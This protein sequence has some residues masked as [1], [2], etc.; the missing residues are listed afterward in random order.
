[1]NFKSIFCLTFCVLFLLQFLT[2][3]PLDFQRNRNIAV[4][5]Q[6]RTL[7]H[8][9]AGGLNTPQFSEID[10][11]SD[12]IQDLFVFDKTTNKVLTFINKGT[13]NQQD[14]IYTPEYVFQFPPLQDW[15][16]LRDYNADGVADIFTYSIEGAGVSVYR[17]KRTSPNSLEFE[18]TSTRLLFQG[19]NGLSNILVTRID[20]PAIAD[21]TGDGDLDILTFDSFGNYVEHYENQS[22]ELTGTAGDTLW[23]ERVDRCWGKFAEDSFTNSVELNSES[24]N[25]KSTSTSK[26][27]TGS[28]LLALDIDD[29]KDQDLLM[30]DLSFV[31]LVLLTNGGTAENTI[32]TE[33]DEVFPKNDKAVNISIFPA[34]YS[35]DANNDGLKDIIVA[36]NEVKS[37]TYHQVWAYFNKGTAQNPAF[38]RQTQ[39]FLIEDMIDVGEGAYPAFVDYNADGLMDF[40]VGNKG[41]FDIESEFY[42][43][44]RLTLFENIGSAEMPAFRLADEDYFDMSQHHFRGVY[45]TFGDVDGD[46]DDDLIVGNEAGALHYFENTAAPNKALQLEL[47]TLE[48]LTLVPNDYSAIP[49]LVDIDGDEKVDLLVG[50]AKGSIFYFRNFTPIEAET[51]IFSIESEKWGSISMREPTFSRGSAAPIVTTLDDTETRY[52]I[53]QNEGGDLSLFTDLQQDT[54][55]LVTQ[56][57]SSINEGGRGGLAITDLDGDGNKSLL[58]GNRRGGVALYS[59]SLVWDDIE[60]N[61]NSN[62]AEISI[63]PNPCSSLCEIRL[64]GFH[65]FPS[66]SPPVFTFYNIEGKQIRLNSNLSSSHR[67]LTIDVKHLPKGIYFFEVTTQNQ[68]KV[69]KLLVN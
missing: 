63:F 39:N 6:N 4:Q 69:G 54:F 26:V 56:T 52:L 64:E 36:P 28:T 32:M 46:G 48:L 45:P 5:D 57:Y 50:T 27:H 33:Q 42:K 38:E 1:M 68:R 3:Q 22:Q 15:V 12:G 41:N 21:I 14:Y 66:M 7:Q 11:N 61:E 20:I 23:F 19:T 31:N 25:G 40:V 17:G 55:T 53:V 18:L 58:V 60:G 37:Q 16:L 47:N 10:F 67:S 65:D 29:D 43:D 13:S 34:A 62:N 49:F 2:A 59:Q 24:C 35:L 8:A 51:P 30:G 44:A 9:W